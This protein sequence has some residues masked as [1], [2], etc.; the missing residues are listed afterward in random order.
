MKPAHK[1]VARCV[2]Y[3]LTLANTDAWIALVEVL[4]HRLTQAERVSLAYAALRSVDP[5]IRQEVYQLL[6]D[7]PELA[8][9]PMPPFGELQDDAAFWAD[10][11][12]AEER[13]AYLMAC[14]KRLDDQ[15]KQALLKVLAG[16]KQ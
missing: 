5:M 16:E 9:S 12:G 3:A 4:A 6:G 1:Q 15:S 2:G 14:W 13:A 7:L 10:L 8:G 11:A